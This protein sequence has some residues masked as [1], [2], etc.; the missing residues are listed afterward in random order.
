MADFAADHSKAGFETTIKMELE[1]FHHE[2]RCWVLRFD[3]CSTRTS[4]GVGIVMVSTFGI[5]TTMSFQLNFQCFNDQAK[6]E[7]LIIGLELLKEMGAE[8]VEILKDS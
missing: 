5:K 1:N 8:N 4:A 6:K 7:A 3:G 2:L